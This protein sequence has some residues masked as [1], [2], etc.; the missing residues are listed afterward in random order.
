[1]IG[2]SN[3]H[4][5]RIHQARIPQH[6]TL[7]AMQQHAVVAWLTFMLLELTRT[8]R[9]V[10]T[11]RHEVTLVRTVQQESEPGEDVP[12]EDDRKHVMRDE[13][14]EEE[15]AAV[16]GKVPQPRPI[17]AFVGFDFHLNRSQVARSCAR[18]WRIAFAWIVAQLTLPVTHLNT[19]GGCLV[20]EKFIMSKLTLGG[21]P[22][23]CP[24]LKAILADSH[25]CKRDL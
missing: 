14:H 15:Q 10:G 7:G 16:D 1:M 18:S 13:P 5:R 25:I 23:C 17:P 4:R 12:G 20:P 6:I 21:A 24:M 3:L 8:F 2:R 22:S 9:A 19:T 11:R